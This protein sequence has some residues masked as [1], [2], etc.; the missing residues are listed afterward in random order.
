MS[1]VD[2]PVRAFLANCDD[3]SW[4]RI[5][6]RQPNSMNTRAVGAR[7]RV[8]TESGEYIRWVLAGTSLS[9]SAPLEA[10]FGLGTAESIQKVEIIWPD[11]TK[12]VMTDI[13]INQI[14]QI[15]RE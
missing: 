14:V 11:Q 4:V 6:L 3:S 1:A 5:Q 2:G 13:A 12:S 10:H 9:S 15:I 8:T 7:I